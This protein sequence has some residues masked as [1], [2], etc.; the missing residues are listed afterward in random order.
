LY[1]SVSATIRR[2]KE[3]QIALGIVSTKYRYR[4]ES[5]LKREDLL[6]CFDAIIGG[7]DVSRHK[8]DPEGL[9][10]ALDRL[11]SSRGDT[12]YVGDSIVDAETARRAGVRFVAVLSGVTSREAYREYDTWRVLEHIGELPEVLE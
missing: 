8:P 5:V 9:C 3:R 10:L 11:V 2:L 7:E 1:P 12:L 6:A 4:I